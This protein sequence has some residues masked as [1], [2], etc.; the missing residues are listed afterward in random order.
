MYGDALVKRVKKVLRSLKVALEGVTSVGKH[1][2]L[3]AY[4]IIGSHG[5]LEV[6]GHGGYSW[7][8][9]P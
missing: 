7:M 5:D 8:I 4:R 2:L 6:E 3:M 1:T 9:S